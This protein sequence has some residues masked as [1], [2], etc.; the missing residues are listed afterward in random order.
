MRKGLFLGLLVLM[1]CT[2]ALVGM[3]SVGAEGDSS[4]VKHAL[5]TPTPAPS[6]PQLWHSP[7]VLTAQGSGARAWQRTG[8]EGGY[9]RDI[10]AA[11][12]WVFATVGNSDSHVFVSNGNLWR[13]TG[14]RA[15]RVA[16]APD[17]GAYVSIWRDVYRSLDGG[18]TWTK[19]QEFDVPLAALAVDAADPQRVLAAGEG[20]VMVSRDGGAT[21]GEAAGPSLMSIVAAQGH[22]YALKVAWQGVMRSADGLTWQDIALPIAGITDLAVDPRN[23]LTV[24]AVGAGRLFLS[25]DGGD[26][27][28]ELPGPPGVQNWSPRDTLSVDG[29]GT[30]FATAGYWALESGDWQWHESLYKLVPEGWVELSS[31]VVAEN[32][33]A[34]AGTGNALWLASCT[35]GVFRSHDAGS[36]WESANAGLYGVRG[37]GLAVFQGK[38]YV[39][40]DS[41]LYVGTPATDDWQLVETPLA[42]PGLV[43]V[44]SDGSY[45]YAADRCSLVRR[46]GAGEWEVVLPASPCW[47]INGMM[48]TASGLYVLRGNSALL[49]SQDQGGTW[50]ELPLIGEGAYTRAV[51]D[52]L[53]G[54]Y[55]GTDQGLYRFTG[56]GW[57]AV[58]SLPET[59]VRF[60]LST[61][62]G[63]YAATGANPPYSGRGLFVSFD[64]GASWEARDRGLTDDVA[65]LVDDSDGTLYAGGGDGVFSTT[66]GGGRWRALD[67]GLPPA[68]FTSYAR[69]TDGVSVH[70]LALVPDGAHYGVLAATSLGLLWLPPSEETAGPKL[71]L[72]I[73]YNH[74]APKAVLIVG[75]VDPPD[76]T[77][78]RSF[79]QWSDRLAA[80]LESHGFQVVKLYFQDATWPR[81]RQAIAGASVVVYKGHG[82]GFGEVPS[83]RGE[84]G[85]G[86][87]GFCLYNPDQPAGA[88]LATQDMLISTTDLAPGALVF[89]FACYSGG[90]SASDTS[91]VSQE[92]AERR[93]EG[94]AFTFQAIGASVYMAACDEEAILGAIL[95]NPNARIADVYCQVHGCQGVHRFTPYFYPAA[96]GLFRAFFDGDGRQTGWGAAMVADPNWTARRILGP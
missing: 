88:Q 35:R 59:Q 5:F 70:Y 84:M 8:P 25:S 50:Q 2:L 74:P 21:W 96:A 31:P 56:T 9:V 60:L 65:V 22:A 11:G 89:V 95:T 69:L 40:D 3:P 45:L 90:S 46:S 26:K 20:R 77:G 48:V 52:H 34:L 12:T 79:M 42:G 44:V 37:N 94:Y 14:M 71:Y 93:I 1:A 66:N 7:Q 58:G 54:L 16:C 61:G 24:Y 73:A 4:R 92:L 76:H 49:R 19:A 80:I 86:I 13:T 43:G 83:D 6:L 36:T 29:A 67:N 18:T 27:W 32:V 30:L 75:P 57:Q 39:A 68:P 53:G 15:W 17:G 41:G 85:G 72:P 63:L 62:G 82:F 10:C 51:V 23:G 55:V 91:V 47:G 38:A 81:V 28:Q 64:N 78:T 87:N 33:T